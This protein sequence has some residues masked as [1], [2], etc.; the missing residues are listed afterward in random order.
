MKMRHYIFSRLATASATVAV[1]GFVAAGPVWAQQAATAGDV[2]AESAT[3]SDKDPRAS[4]EEREAKL[5]EMIGAT[6]E[7]LSKESTDGAKV[8]WAV[9]KKSV[10]DAL[11]QRAI[12][13]NKAPVWPDSQL[14]WAQ[15]ARKSVERLGDKALH[16][17]EDHS[18]ELKVLESLVVAL[19]ESPAEAK[20][21]WRQ[22]RAR[23]RKLQTTK[24]SGAIVTRAGPGPPSRAI[25]GKNP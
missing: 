8:D 11:F 21:K 13:D 18:S 12:S 23:R 20:R 2:K 7:S 15:G 17:G 4:W 24:I 5:I 16:E 25:R 6:V 22:N 10:A 1:L 3:D 9:V 19:K 14:T